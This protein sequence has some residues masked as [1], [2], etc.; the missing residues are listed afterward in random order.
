MSLLCPFSPSSASRRHSCGKLPAILAILLLASGLPLRAELRRE[1][2]QNAHIALPFKDSF[3]SAEGLGK[4]PPGWDGLNLDDS[5]GF[6]ISNVNS[7]STPQALELFALR[8][9]AEGKT[10]TLFLIV[11][12][13]DALW[14][15]F[16]FYFDPKDNYFRAG[17]GTS[18]SMEFGVTGVNDRFYAV[19]REA[20]GQM[21]NSPLPAEYLRPRQ[22]NTISIGREANGGRIRINGNVVDV[23]TQ[24]SPQ[25]DYVKFIIGSPD[26][27]A[28]SS[29]LLIDNVTIDRVPVGE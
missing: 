27:K 15:T 9:A 29:R 10:A 3:D 6:S 23:E 20:N 7:S 16:D 8:P 18:G 22:W 2:Q 17:L 13:S 14:L 11:E 26:P 25:M 28:A 19:K 12:K 5:N 21:T 4:F 1:F 24:G